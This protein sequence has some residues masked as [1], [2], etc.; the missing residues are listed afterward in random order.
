MGQDFHIIVESLHLPGRGE[1][2]NAHNLPAD[3]LQQ[4]EVVL[5]DIAS[6]I[7]ESSDYKPEYDPAKFHSKK[8]NRGPLERNWMKTVSHFK[9]WNKSG[10]K[11]TLFQ[12]C[13]E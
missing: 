11:E 13:N 6:E 9:F 2:E 5:I 7:T 1:I 12:E 10:A 4:R 3:K 8:T